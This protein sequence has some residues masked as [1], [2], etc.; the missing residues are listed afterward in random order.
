MINKRFKIIASLAIVF[1][2]NIEGAFASSYNNTDRLEKIIRNNLKQWEE[3]FE[4]PYYSSDIIN[5][6]KES[7]DD[8]Q[9]LRRSIKSIAVRQKGKKILV[10]IT[11]RTSR[12]EEEYIDT[13]LEPVVKNIAGENMSD[14]EK[15]K[16]INKYICDEF[17]Y[18]TTLEKDNT[19]EGLTTGFTTCNGYAMTASKMFSM[20]GLENKIVLGT[21]DGISHGWNEVKIDG[22]WYNIDVTNND[23]T[24][25]DK[26]FLKSDDSF[27]REGFV[28]NDDKTYEPC[29][30]D[31]INLAVLIE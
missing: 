2:L 29:N 19:Y 25:S 3:E 4:I 17:Q 11:Y 26:Y 1:S 10:D 22:K 8:D 7:V 12:E 15:V 13:V 28:W 18:D 30:E 20:A 6:I 9:Y 14:Y 23:Y 16:A 5:V 24:S 31:Y 21:L 27:K